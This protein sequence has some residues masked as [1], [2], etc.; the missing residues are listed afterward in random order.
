M[1]VSKEQATQWA[2]ETLIPFIKQAADDLGGPADRLILATV[3]R[4]AAIAGASLDEVLDEVRHH[5]E[6]QTSFNGSRGI[7]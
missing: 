5:F 1:V 7:H 6:H 2:K 4:R 3:V